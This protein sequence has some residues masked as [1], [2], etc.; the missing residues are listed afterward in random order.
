MSFKNFIEQSV[1][2]AINQ[3]I[4]PVLFGL[5]FAAFVW[6]VVQYFILNAGNEEARS[7]GRQFALWGLLG[8][9]LLFTAWGVV[10]ILLDIFGIKPS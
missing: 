6:G 1:V 8:L 4:L 5:A 2:G 9:V 10:Y 3:F 7:K